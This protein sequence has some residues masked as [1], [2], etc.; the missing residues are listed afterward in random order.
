[1]NNNSDYK[2]LLNQS[3][4]GFFKDVLKVIYKNPSLTKFIIQT[5]AAQEK[6]AK[7]RAEYDRQGITVPPYMFIS[8][9]NR[10]N[11]RCQGCYAQAQHRPAEKEIDHDKLQAVISEARDLGVSFIFLAGGE[12]LL[13][14]DTL[15]I[16][17]EVPEVIFPLFT[18][19]LLI[20]DNIID[21]LKKQRNVIPVISLEGCQRETDA[22]RGAGVF[23][24][25]RETLA[26]MKKAGVFYGV[27]FTVS[28][29][30]FSTLT[31]E[32]FI[33]ELIALGCQL[34]FY[35]EYVPVQEETDHM[36]IA[37]DQ[38]ATLPGILDA[39]RKNFPALFVSFP[40]DE[41]MYGGCLSAGR[42]FIHISAAGD[43]EPCPFAP[44]SDTNLKGLSLKEALKSELLSKIRANYAELSETHG[45]CAL[46]NKREWV[47]SL[48]E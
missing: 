34:F 30:N 45:G 39:F 48:L 42:G 5:V 33:N 12:P 22:R 32:V 10:C 25:L 44:F 46:W 47:K 9:T 35:V 1:M 43:L 18:N 21:I 13:R 31:D 3:I 41:E 24:R 11:L 36:V 27:S 16:T 28:Q 23:L 40:G 20:N 37:D 19:G 6:A 7:R 2:T 29:A 14:P 38:R 4:R 17:R 26:K 8:I 15:E